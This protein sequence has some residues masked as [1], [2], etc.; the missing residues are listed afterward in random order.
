MV[1][2]WK[3]GRAPRRRARRLARARERDSVI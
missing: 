3:W 1:T 2:S